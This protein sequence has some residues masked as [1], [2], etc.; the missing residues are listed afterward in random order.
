MNVYDLARQIQTSSLYHYRRVILSHLL[1]VMLLHPHATTEMVYRAR[2]QC[3]HVTRLFPSERRPLPAISNQ[4]GPGF[5]LDQNCRCA[6]AGLVLTG[7]D[8]AETV[9]P[10]RV[11]VGPAQANFLSQLPQDVLWIYFNGRPAF[12]KNR[13]REFLQSSPQPVA[14]CLKASIEP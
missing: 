13:S 5:R 8:L 10:K 4:T 14:P 1:S 7:F 2:P 12:V 3:Q 9:H 11:Q 6:P